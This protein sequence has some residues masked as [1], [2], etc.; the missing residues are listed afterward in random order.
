MPS[1]I[2]SHSSTR[3][4]MA[5]GEPVASLIGILVSLDSGAVLAQALAVVLKRA[6]L[7]D[8]RVKAAQ[9]LPRT[10]ADDVELAA[11]GHTNMEMRQERTEAGLAAK[12]VAHA[13]A[14]RV[15]SSA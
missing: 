4:L 8:L 5:A 7:D 14:H 6:L 11:A 2:S 15:A 12:Y 3:G 1:S 10:R 9:R 13:S